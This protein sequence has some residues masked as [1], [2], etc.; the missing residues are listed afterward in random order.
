MK[1]RGKENILVSFRAY[2][3]RHFCLLKLKNIWGEMRE[4]FKDKSLKEKDKREMNWFK[5]RFPPKAGMKE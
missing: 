2:P 4:V 3:K 5:N 1:D